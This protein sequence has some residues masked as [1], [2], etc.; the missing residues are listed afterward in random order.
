MNLPWLSDDPGIV[1]ASRVRLARNLDGLPFRGALP[2]SAARDFCERVRSSLDP[3][4]Y[5]TL[6]SDA[7]SDAVEL[8]DSLTIPT[9]LVEN[10]SPW[11]ALRKGA[12]GVLVLHDDHLRAWALR[13]GFDFPGALD[14]LVEVESDIALLGPFSRDPDWG[15]RT[16]SPEDVGTGLRA[17]ALLH[18]PALWLA[19][20]LSS[21]SD[22]LD[23]LGGRLR[24]AWHG[25]ALGP[26]VVASN[27][28]TLGRSELDL[29][30][31]LERWTR[32]ISE[33]E[34]RAARDL[35][36]HWGG[37][38]RDAVQRSDAVLGAARLMSESE[39]QQRMALLALGIR[40]GWLPNRRGGDV[41]RLLLGTR[42]GTLRARRAGEI[43]EGHAQLD[44]L[45]ASEARVLWGLAG[46]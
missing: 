44:D 24:C 20:R 23:V 2:P 6:A 22:G 35:V 18:V 16:A 7:S 9:D 43:P 25:E 13:P 11:L 4:G 45:R 29:L 39:L 15:W 32:R 33:E 5:G 38:L 3:F 42:Q 40:L 21:L 12:R 8:A 36:E 26:L 14:D 17:G 28:I 37:E 27:R 31:D 19:R 41:L 10:G 30:H 34:E 1:L 46:E